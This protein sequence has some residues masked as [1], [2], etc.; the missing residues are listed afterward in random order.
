MRA[1]KC[2]SRHPHPTFVTCQTSGPCRVAPRCL[3]CAPAPF[4]PSPRPSLRA[5]PTPSCS[6]PFPGSRTGPNGAE[7]RSRAETSER[8][9]A[10]LTRGSGPSGTYPGLGAQPTERGRAE[11]SGA[12]L[13]RIGSSGAERGRAGPSR[14]EPCPAGL[15]GAERRARAV[16]AAAAMKRDRLGRFLSPGTAGQRGGSGGGGGG[17]CGSGR[18]RGRPA[19]SGPSVDEAAA[20][21]AARLG[22]G[23]ARARGDTG[24]DGADEA[25]TGRAL[26]MGHC[27]LC[28]GKFS[29]RSLRSISGRAPGESADRPPPGER[30]FI[31]DFQHLLGVAVHQDPALSQFV[32]KNCHAQFYQCHGLLKSFLQR[33]NVSPAGHR[34]TCT[35][36]GAQP[37]P[38]AEE[39]ACLVDLITSSPQGLRDLV[40]WVHGHAASCGALPSLQRTLSS[41]Y[42]GVIRAVWGC[43]QGH[44]YTMDADSS[45]GALL[46]DSALA[47][48]WTWDKE[49]A[50]W[51][52]Q[53]RGSNPT[54]AAPQSS[55]GRATTTPAETESLPGADAAPP[56]SDVNP[57]GPGLCPPPQPSFPPSGA[58]GRLG[59][60]QVPSST[61]DDRVKDEFSDL[62]EGD[63]LSEDENDKKQST[64]SSDESFEPYPEKK[65]SGKKSESKEAKK[66]EEPKMRKKPGPKPGWKNKL[67]CER[68]EL[69]TIYKCPYQGC[70]AVYRGADGMK[71]HIKEH[72]EEVRERP[73]PHPGCNKVFMIDRYLQRHVK[74]IHT[75]L[76]KPRAA[77]VPDSDHC[78]SSQSRSPELAAPP[79]KDGH[80]EVR[81]YICDECGQTFKQRKHLLVHQMRH[82]GAKPLQCEVCGFQCRQRASLKYHMTKHKAETELD[83][84]C[85]QCGRRFEKAHNLNVHMSMVHP[86]TQT[87]DKALPLEPPCGTTEGQAVKPEPT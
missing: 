36:V 28:H 72:H 59:E 48:K 39:G 49:M 58:P 23:L 29:S 7:R 68:E 18:T 2:N 10:E 14:A 81:N 16:A 79:L 31:R 62:S 66:A 25:G 6:A 76:R 54:G 37:P 11:P 51:L 61:S 34:K 80:L 8:S 74:L 24:E 5:P 60:K 87:Q 21:V 38:G 82:S 67:R 22:W 43:D 63:I 53:H 71:K 17:A 75:G 52:T 20:L 64:Q 57:V 45:C 47:V 42:C 46:L 44:D 85:D 41:E 69:P 55:Q 84:A 1:R 4:S 3:H 35:K 77:R 27:R 9:P 65:V 33:V 50:P 26:A 73:C 86:L 30:V 19:R 15:S 83:F 40:A 78:C 56:P 12:E 13:G 32:C 70:T